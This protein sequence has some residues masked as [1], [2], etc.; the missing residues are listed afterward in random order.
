VWGVVGDGWGGG[1]VSG[2]EWMKGAK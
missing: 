2:T 1:E